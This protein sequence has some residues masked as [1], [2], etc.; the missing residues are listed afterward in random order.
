MN[1]PIVWIL[2]AAALGIGYFLRHRGLGL[3]FLGKPAAP[4]TPAMG[5]TARPARVDNTDPAA[6]IVK[7]IEDEKAA[8]DAVEKARERREVLKKFVN[9]PFSTK[10]D[11]KE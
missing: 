6:W 1:E 4:T 3:E 8:Q 9:E 5:V 10:S 7:M 2:A 11:K